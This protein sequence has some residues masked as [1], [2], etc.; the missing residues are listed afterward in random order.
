VREEGPI[1]RTV[2]KFA[3]HAE[4]IV[5]IITTTFVILLAVWLFF[6]PPDTITPAVVGVILGGLGLIGLLLLTL[7]ATT[8]YEIQNRL[9]DVDGKLEKIVDQESARNK[10]IGQIQHYMQMHELD[11]HL[12]R[13]DPSDSS[14]GDVATRLL[15]DPIDTLE[16]LARGRIEVPH[17]L[18]ALTF[19]HVIDSYS[20]RFDA[21]SYDD[22]HF[23]SSTKETDEKYREAGYEATKNII[24]TR[25][26]IIPEQHLEHLRRELIQVLEQHMKKNIGWSLVIDEDLKHMRLPGAPDFALFDGG[27]AVSFFRGGL[28]RKFEVIFRTNGFLKKNDEEIDLQLRRYYLLL[29]QCWLVSERFSR[30]HLWANDSS[31]MDEL[32]KLAKNRNQQLAQLGTGSINS[33]FPL[34]VPGSA[35]IEDGL[36]Q[37]SE[38]RRRYRSSR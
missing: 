14:F 6:S 32:Q 37:L 22:L 8:L 26:F 4:S 20:V 17:Y 12:R 21:V 11:R 9:I 13:K 16:S 29:T 1:E 34:I 38:L 35:D 15:S 25:L 23:W 33:I 5:L 28:S 24:V 18:V 19:D 31:K 30:Q 7:R 3:K 36:S 27:K 10:Y 2:L